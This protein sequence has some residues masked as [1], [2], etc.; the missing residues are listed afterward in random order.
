MGAVFAKL[1]P[2]HR[3]ANRL[4]HIGLY[5][6]FLFI[7]FGCASGATVHEHPEFKKR[8]A[9]AKTTMLAPPDVV[10]IRGPSESTGTH[11][12]E[13]AAKY[14][15]NLSNLVAAELSHRGFEV[16]LEPAQDPADNNLNDNLVRTTSIEAPE[17]AGLAKKV[18]ASCIIF[19]KLRVL[20][21]STGDILAEGGRVLLIG[22]LTAGLFVPYKEPSGWATLQVELRDGVTGEVLWG[23]L[24]HETSLFS[25][26]EPDFLDNLNKMVADLFKPFPLQERQ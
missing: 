20:K 17:V 5:S 14:A 19:A 4:I 11:L 15:K 23:N 12:P 6:G 13:E 7:L 25:L 9:A 22:M 1:L 21:R 10:V 8:I 2:W 3:R 18:G 24:T 16:K 26:I